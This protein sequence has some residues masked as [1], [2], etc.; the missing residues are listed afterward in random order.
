MSDHGSPPLSSSVTLRVNIKDRNTHA[1]IFHNLP[2]AIN[3]SEMT[4][5][6]I[7]LYQVSATDADLEEN[8]KM[9]FQII[10]GMD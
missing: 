4:T 6:N 7:Q 9:N 5:S 10:A 3:I 8:A 1:P 2:R